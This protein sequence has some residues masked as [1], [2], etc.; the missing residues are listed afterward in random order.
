LS[1]WQTGTI[2]DVFS[3]YNYLVELS[4]GT[5]KNIHANFLRPFAV[6]V[7]SVIID[8]DEDFGEI[9]S[10]P[11]SE[12]P[13]RPSDEISKT[14]VAHLSDVQQQQLLDL[15]DEFAVCFSS[16]PG[17]L[18]SVEHEIVTLPGFKRK[19]F[20]PYKIPESLKSEVE[21]QIDVLLEEGFIVPSNSDMISP[22]VCV[23]KPD[24]FNTGRR[25]VRIVCD[26][27]YLNKYTAMDPFPVPDQ[28][29]AMNKLASFK[30]I[31]LFDA[32]SG[33]WH[34]KV[35]HECQELLGFATHHGLWQWTRTPFGCKNSGSTFLRAIEHVVR[36]LRDITATYVDDM[37]VG[38]NSWEEHLVNLRRFFT[39]MKKA[40][41]TLN[42]AK[43]EFAKNTVKFLGHIVGS[44]YKYPDP[45][46]V[47]AIRSIPRPR[48]RKQ[49]KS[50]LGAM[51]Y[52]RAY[53][54]HFAHVAK[55]LTDL[56]AGKS[57]TNILWSEE[58]E[59]AFLTLKD[60][61]C[62]VVA[63]SVPRIGGLFILRVDAS[64]TAVSGCL[65]QR[66]DDD[67]D[68]VVVSGDGEK[69]ISFF[70][71]KLSRSQVAWSVIEREAFA[72]IA[73]LRKFHHLIFGSMIVV[74]SDHN[75]L[76]FLVEGS[77]H[78]AKLTRWSLALQEYNI[79]FR[80]AKAQHNRVA[81]YFSRCVAEAG[82]DIS[83]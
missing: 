40:G 10:V 8:V 80:Y 59:R 51:S 6:R 23:L 27:R 54:D 24:K 36:P 66:D 17:L 71:K 69:P 16:K 15:L 18:T 45:A 25:E 70:S 73:S 7:N 55:P 1:E 48:T 29:E 75:P 2:R 26:F 68:H 47:V 83:S 62:S 60:K 21:K 14:A 37:G 19:R 42:L 50:F 4:S 30:Y 58:H 52:H 74:Y 61:L 41:V 56:T 5:R 77:T 46:K 64:G 28:D 11:V 49:L 3:E 72:V 44:G 78:S 76:S 35:K 33:Y 34:T 79:V 53:I 20:K 22:M 57:T 82:E 63:L 12:G 32:R 65:Y 67:L 13:L 9:L 39:V 43:S 31:S 81:D 38:S